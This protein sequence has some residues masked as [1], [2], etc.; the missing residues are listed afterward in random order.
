[1]LRSRTFVTPLCS[2]MLL[3]FLR[4][5]SVA[6]AEEKKTA[7]TEGKVAGILMEKKKEWLSV[8]ADGE[9]EP[10]KYLIGDPPDKK[11]DEVAKE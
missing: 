11:L 10:V 2:V 6:L 8:K 1:M 7:K 9:E 4:S 3:A 5:G